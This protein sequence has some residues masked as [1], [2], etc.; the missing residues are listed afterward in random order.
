MNL[1]K[2][3]ES[4]VNLKGDAQRDAQK[5]VPLGHDLARIV[6]LWPRLSQNLKAAILA[7]IQSA[8]GGL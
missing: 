2:G 6:T 4:K 1:L 3:A 8:E 5:P 7:I